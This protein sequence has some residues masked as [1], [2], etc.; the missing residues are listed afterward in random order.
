M[1]YSC[2]D[3]TSNYLCI[4]FF[5]EVSL[6]ELWYKYYKDQN[7]FFEMEK[8][9]VEL[10]PF[11]QQ[12]HAFVRERLYTVYGDK[13]ID[14]EGPIPDHLFQ[15]VLIQAWKNGSIMES[16][17]P[18]GDLPPY[19]EFVQ[20]NE[21]DAEKIL[22][23]ADNFYL[24]LGLSPLSDDFWKKRFKMYSKD[25]NSGDCKADI[26]DLTPNVYMKYCPQVD[27][28]KLMQAHGFMGRFH[29]VMEKPNLPA[30]FFNSYDLQYPL[31]EAVV[32]SASTPKHLS[33]IGLA[34]NY[35]FTDDV[36]TN[37]LFRMVSVMENNLI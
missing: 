17:L 18:D 14:P 28:R 29:Y 31:G 10:K 12:L 13:V 25:R 21:F 30:Y 4:F 19:D 7:F 32:L 34:S 3:R 23:V 35:T 11:Y 1:L 16:S 8:V 27:F 2:Y 5:A 22:E 6:L 24:S 37:R 9:M 26:F 36:I 15:Q 20:D 33:A